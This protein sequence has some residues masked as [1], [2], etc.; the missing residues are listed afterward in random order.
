MRCLLAPC[1]L[2]LGFLEVVGE[3]DR[4][5]ESITVEEL[6]SLL[7]KSRAHHDVPALAAGF[8]RGSEE[9]CM[10]V[11]GVR[12][13]GTDTPATVDDHW[14][15]GSNSKPI[16]SL[17]VA[18]LIDLGLLD[19]DTP[20]EQIFPEYAGEWSAD[21]KKITPAHLLTHT[22]GLPANWPLGWFLIGTKGTPAEQRN[23]V[24]KNLGTIKLK[25]KPGEAYQYSNLGYVVLGAILD[26][27]GK[28][29]WEEQIE[30]KIF[31][32]LGIKNW[33][34]G[35]AGNKK[36]LVQPWPHHADGKA[37]APDGLMDNPPVLNSAG[38]IHISI[39]DYNRFL[40]ETLKLSRGDKGLLK[41]ATAKK[42][43]S[44]PY[45]ASPH[46]L[47]GWVG[48]RKQPGDKGLIL[49]HDGSNSLNYCTAAVV[50]DQNLAF[51]VLTN[52]GTLGGPGQKAC[53]EV[54]KK[55]APKKR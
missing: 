2:L 23:G 46:S 50:P 15:L 16:T 26:V 19:W 8:I 48:F 36:A 51:C 42:L 7:E 29:S 17:L 44:N 20:L 18:L 6:R 9:P 43:F 28:V 41:P 13:R 54:V 31:Q 10:A 40:A 45:P 55:L 24:V 53:R 37:V 35:P 27:R 33:G 52:Q 39:A 38:R 5:D 3:T 30:K 32:P 34:L 12:K 14:H 25:T 22:S 49:G 11:V 4:R 1:V 21:L 47:S